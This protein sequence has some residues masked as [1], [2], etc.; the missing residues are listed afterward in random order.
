M[1]LIRAQKPHLIQERR[2]SELAQ[3]QLWPSSSVHAGLVQPSHVIVLTVRPLALTCLSQ[4]TG[5]RDIVYN[6]SHV[7]KGEKSPS[8][9]FNPTSIGLALV[10][11]N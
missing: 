9:R 6:V 11:S 10:S 3:G 8:L 7:K 2:V 4:L 5:R 1:H